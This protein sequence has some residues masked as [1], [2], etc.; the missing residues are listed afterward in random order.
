MGISKIDV[1]KVAK[2]IEADAGEALPDLRQA[3][4]EAKAGVGRVTTPEQIIVRQAREKSGLTQA[5][6]AERIE[7]PVATLRDWEQGRFAP[8]GGVLCLLRLIIK[9]PELSEELSVV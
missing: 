8:P 9:H 6:F 3:L 4:A 5:A 7:T 2:A 1:E